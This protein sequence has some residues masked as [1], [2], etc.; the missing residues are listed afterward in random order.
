MSC[1]LSLFSDLL[2]PNNNHAC[3]KENIGGSRSVPSSRRNS[4]R[5]ES[6]S[7]IL[8]QTGSRG[9]LDDSTMALRSRGLREQRHSAI[10]ISHFDQGSTAGLPVPP[11]YLNIR[12]KSSSAAVT[13]AGVQLNRFMTWN[14][15]IFFPSLKS[16]YLD[17]ASL[18]TKYIVEKEGRSLGRKSVQNTSS[19]LPIDMSRTILS[20]V[21]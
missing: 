10:D 18:N 14:A 20:L 16:T 1:D 15:I 8:S 2:Q 19:P 17:Y 5:I 11:E 3:L 7:P 6:S 9:S 21:P 13:A 12:R 4:G